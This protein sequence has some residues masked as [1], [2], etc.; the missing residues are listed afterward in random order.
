MRAARSFS[1]CSSTLPS[2]LWRRPPRKS[3]QLTEPLWSVMEKV[4]IFDWPFLVSRISS[5]ATSP[6]TVMRP[7][8]SVISFMGMG[9]SWMTRP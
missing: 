2:S 1:A 7:M 9:S 5:A 6:L 3:L 8:S 4:T